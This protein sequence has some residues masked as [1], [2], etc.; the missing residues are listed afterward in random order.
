[1]AR[2]SGSTWRN[3]IASKRSLPR[4]SESFEW[5]PPTIRW[6][7]TEKAS[8]NTGAGKPCP[9][10]SVRSAEA[11]SIPSSPGASGPSDSSVRAR[12]R[13]RQ[14]LPGD[15]LEER[16]E[17]RQIRFGERQPG[18]VCVSAELREE[19]RRALGDEVQ[20]VAQMEAGDRPA[21][22]LEL[23]AASA[24]EYDGG[25]V[26]PVLEPSGDDADD[27]LMPAGVEQAERVGVGM[28]GIRGACFQRDERVF[29]HRGFDIAA[30]AIEPVELRG[31][32]CRL[33]LAVGE[34]A[35]DAER[36]VGQP[37]RRIEARSRDKAQV[38]AGRTP[39][40]AAARGEE[41]VDAGLRAAGADP[42]EALRDQ[43]PVDPVERD[44][45]GHR[46]ERDEIEQ[47]REIRRRAVG[48]MAA[49]AQR[50]AR[51]EQHVEHD[52]DAGEVLARKG[53]SG[54]IRVD[55]QRGG[56]ERARR[57]DGDRSPALRCRRPPPPRRR[58]GS[59]CRGRRSR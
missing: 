57:A 44:D 22:S 40:V 19:P 10:T 45:V 58:R 33:R 29:L 27:A 2:G 34:E 53:A 24:R 38:V 6:S 54:L 20:R 39:R 7:S 12:S 50:R 35:A 37:S 8:S 55:D 28:G 47:C 56:R 46:A 48:E 21:R 26:K 41:R 4:D 18:G 49:F 9:Q 17:S 30:F 5:C 51:G 15:R 11:S 1:M 32:R 3:R 16:G 36:H 59:R 23:A 42:F 14:L 13:R 31:E 52:A 25:P 43:R